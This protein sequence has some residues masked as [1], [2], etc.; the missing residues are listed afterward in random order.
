[1]MEEFGEM[2]CGGCFIFVYFVIIILLDEL[3][4]MVFSCEEIWEVIVV[5]FEVNLL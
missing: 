2:G 1:M 3:E 4:F 5:Y